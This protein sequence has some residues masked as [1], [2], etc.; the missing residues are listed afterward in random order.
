[1]SLYTLR[2]DPCVSGGWRGERKFRKF[3]SQR[4]GKRPRE[5]HGGLLI[6]VYVA[7]VKTQTGADR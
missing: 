3:R 7:R 6:P 2:F 1:M 5:N 4:S